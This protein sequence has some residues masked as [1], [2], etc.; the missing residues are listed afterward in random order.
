MKWRV[1]CGLLGAVL[2]GGY[3]VLKDGAFE[4]FQADPSYYMGTYIGAAIIGGLIG[5]AIGYKLDRNARNKPLPVIRPHG[6]IDNT[7]HQHSG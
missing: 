7:T 5:L 2:W 4:N 1:I 6:G 3:I